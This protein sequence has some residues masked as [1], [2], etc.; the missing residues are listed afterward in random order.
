MMDEPKQ[1]ISDRIRALAAQGRS[2]AE[3]ARL[4]DRSY[5]QVRQVLVGDEARARRLARPETGQA[6]GAARMADRAIAQVDVSDLRSKSDKIRRYAALGFR[7][8]AIADHMGIKYQFVRNVLVG[9]EA[10]HR[11]VEDG[12]GRMGGGVAEPASRYDAGLEPLPARLGV[13]VQGRVRLPPEW[14]VP[15]GAV[16]IARKLGGSIVL[17]DIADA[18]QAARAGGDL[19]SAV[20]GLIAERRLEAMREFD[21]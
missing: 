17:M 4:V 16:F 10:R 7:R 5:Q 3:I 1:S 18:S 15:P 11:T 6:P 13:D 2:R 8:A 21:D 12:T 14:G 20:D 19:D 9:D